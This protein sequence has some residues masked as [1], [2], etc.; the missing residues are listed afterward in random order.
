[1]AMALAVLVGYLL[2]SIPFGLLIARLRRVD[3]RTVGSGNIGAT[4]AARALGKGF[5]VLVL[6]LDAGKAYA[7]VVAAGAYF[8]AHPEPG[9]PVAWIQAAIG[10]SAFLG[11]LFPIFARLRGGKGVATALGAFL[12]LEPRAALAGA[13]VYAVM[14]GITRISSVGSLSAVLSFPLWLYLFGAKPPSYAL[15]VVLLLGI[16]AKHH[17]NIR[18]LFARSEAR[19]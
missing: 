3:L 8:T 13:L 6:L 19:L 18:R 5:G 9:A 17:G 12:A 10:A 14:L 1:M 15:A 4:N 11:H 2:G 16:V 7:P